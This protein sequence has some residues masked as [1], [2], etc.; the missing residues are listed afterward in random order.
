MMDC[1]QGWN[2]NIFRCF[3][4]ISEF[5]TSECCVFVLISAMSAH[6]SKKKGTLSFFFGMLKLMQVTIY[7]ELDLF[8]IDEFLMRYLSFT[9][10]N[11]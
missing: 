2:V 4:S 1:N 8:H 9:P 5:L 7:P 3:L 11:L 10:G 6:C